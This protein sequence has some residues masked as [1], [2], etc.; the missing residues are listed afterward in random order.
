MSIL[1]INITSLT[2]DDVVA[3]CQ[4]GYP[5]GTQLDYK[6]DM[7]KSGLAKHFAAFS[8]P[9]QLVECFIINFIWVS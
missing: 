9:K 4:N 5:E 7:P 8:N 1:N 2:F 3:F 6:I